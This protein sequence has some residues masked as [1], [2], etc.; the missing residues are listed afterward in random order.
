MIIGEYIWLQSRYLSQHCENSLQQTSDDNSHF[1]A[2]QTLKRTPE[3]TRRAL[4][5][6]ATN[7]HA[8]KTSALQ[9]HI[10]HYHI[11]WHI[12]TKNH[13]ITCGQKSTV[14]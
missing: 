1:F 2:I 14:L 13:N 11:P 5:N 7:H 8:L 10:G 3:N 12:I 6:T 4:S 9:I